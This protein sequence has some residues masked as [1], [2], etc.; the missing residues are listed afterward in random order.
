MKAVLIDDELNNLNNLK[1]L[2]E[3]YCPQVEICAMAQTAEQGKT[4]IYTY[5][6]DLLFLDIQM[7]DQDGFALLRSL[8]RYDFEV[9][10]VTAY[11]QYAIQAMRFSAV[12]Y[13]LKPVNITELQAAVARAYKQR[14]LKVQNQQVI[15]LMQWLEAQSKKEDLQVALS[16]AQETRFVKTN[17]IIRCESSNNYTT[18]FLND[19]TKL[20]VSKPIYEYDELLNNYGFLRCHQSHLVNQSFIRSWQK[21]YGDFLLL[22]D[23]TQ[24][25]ISRGKREVVKKALRL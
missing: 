8:T 10:F 7:P 20:L 15:H 25:P 4:A 19:K 5:Q 9:I 23:G 22:T 14:Q 1:A 18:F 21:E 24:I 17:E 13:L 11:D 6:P 2:L 12:D 16:T 3:A